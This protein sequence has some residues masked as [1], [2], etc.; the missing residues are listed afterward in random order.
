MASAKL[1]ETHK[2]GAEIHKGGS[3]KAKTLEFLDE[4]MMPKDLLPLDEIEEIGINR[5][6]S[7][8]W[9][10][11]KKKTDTKFKK[12]GSTVIYGLEIT[13][14]F[15]KRHMYKLTGVKAKEILLPVVVND[16]LVG[17]PEPDMVKFTTPLGI[18]RS[19]P[20]SAFEPEN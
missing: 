19:Y 16:I 13:A 12:I 2:T 1:V 6:S 17:E 10:K 4:V 20:I 7:F 5:S 15:K 8:V 11:L 3:C 14:S 9:L 18:S